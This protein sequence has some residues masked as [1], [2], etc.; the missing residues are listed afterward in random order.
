MPKPLRGRI[1][2]RAMETLEDLE[3]RAVLVVEQAARDVDAKIRCDADDVLV[4]GAMVDRAEGEAV[5][6]DVV[7]AH[8][9]DS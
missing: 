9:L 6:D 5:A 3:H 7:V 8:A 4:E 2:P 1:D